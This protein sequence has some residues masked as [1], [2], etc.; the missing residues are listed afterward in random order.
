VTGAPYPHREQ[1][2]APGQW[3]GAYLVCLVDRAHV[4][5]LPGR[6]PCVTACG[7]PLDDRA[8]WRVSLRRSVRGADVCPTCWGKWLP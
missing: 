1:P 2:P 7:V 8:R 6:L 4:V 3:R 5:H